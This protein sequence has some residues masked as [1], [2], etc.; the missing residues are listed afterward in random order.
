MLDCGVPPRL[1]AERPEPVPADADDASTAGSGTA[2]IP[3]RACGRGWRE[4]PAAAHAAT[5]RRCGR[6]SGTCGESIRRWR[7]RWTRSCCRSRASSAS[8]PGWRRRWA[9][10]PCCGLAAGGAAVPERAPAGAADL[11][12]ATELGRA[13]AGA[14]HR[15]GGRRGAGGGAVGGRRRG[16]ACVA[17]LRMPGRRRGVAGPWESGGSFGAG[18]GQRVRAAGR[19]APPSSG[20]PPTCRRQCA[21]ASPGS[22]RAAPGSRW[23]S[24]RCAASRGASPRRT[25]RCA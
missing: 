19:S 12:R 7:R 13:G 5:A 20:A 22:T 18:A 1:R 14:A 8:G 21:R 9:G 11:R 4:R 17:R 16:H 25:R 6:W 3:T 10:Q 24:R 23:P 15:T 2:T